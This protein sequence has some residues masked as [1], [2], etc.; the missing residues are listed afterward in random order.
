MN[1]RL[2]D[3]ATALLA[4]AIAGRY[5]DTRGRYGPF[6]GRYVPE[7]LVAPIIG[8]QRSRITATRAPAGIASRLRVASTL[9]VAFTLRVVTGLRFTPAL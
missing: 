7:T 2:E 4:D 9:H 6:G 5:P 3:P 8:D 1:A